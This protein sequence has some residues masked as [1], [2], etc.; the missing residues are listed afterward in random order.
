MKSITKYKIV[1]VSYT[2]P[3]SL[4]SYTAFDKIDLSHFKCYVRWKLW[5]AFFAIL[6]MK[7]SYNDIFCSFIHFY[8]LMTLFFVTDK[9]PIY[10]VS[11]GQFGTILSS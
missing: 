8:S 7:F 1:L 2:N 11:H 3:L 9:K 6:F 4:L 10:S 5:H